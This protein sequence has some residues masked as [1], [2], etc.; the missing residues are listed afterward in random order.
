MKNLTECLKEAIKAT[1]TTDDVVLNDLN[2]ASGMLVMAYDHDDPVDTFIISNCT[3]ADINKLKK[4]T[5]LQYD[6]SKYN[7]G[8]VCIHHDDED[9]YIGNIKFNDESAMKAYAEKTVKD[10]D[11]NVDDDVEFDDLGELCLGNDEWEKNPKNAWKDI[12][13]FIKDSEIDNDSSSAY[14]IINPAQQKEM[15]CG[16]MNIM[17]YDNFA[18]FWK[19]HYEDDED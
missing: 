14:A 7:G 9:G 11:F 16:N 5:S 17:F 15:Y 19:E 1:E 2:E 6:T 18:E 3:S 8:F 12:T 13:D 10:W 4:E